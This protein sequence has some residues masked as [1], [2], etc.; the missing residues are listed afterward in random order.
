LARQ[1]TSTAINTLVQIMENEKTPPAARVAASNA[2]LDRA[3]G[4]PPQF[5][6][7]NKRPTADYNQLSDAELEEIILQSDTPPR[8]Q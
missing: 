3:Y 6:H 7:E 4:K 8:R 2:I 5:V 1:H